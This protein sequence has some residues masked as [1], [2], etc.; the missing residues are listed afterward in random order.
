MISVVIPVYNAKK[1]LRQTVNSV[2][3][4]DLK[5]FEIILVDD[6]STDGTETICDE[7]AE[8]T[9]LIRVIHKINRGVSSA[10]N[11]G[12]DASEGEYITF[13]DADDSIEQHMLSDIISEFVEKDAD[14][15]FCGFNEVQENGKQTN[16]IANLPPRRL[17]ERDIVVNSLLYTGCS[18]N[19][20][21]NSVWGRGYKKE[22]IKKHGLRFED[23]PMGE[24]WMFNM[25]YCD[26][27]QS[28]VYIDKAYYR[29]LR[30]SDSATSRYQPRQF[31]LWLENRQY[32]KSLISK[33]N[34]NID[35]T[36]IN[37]TWI[38]NVL[39]YSLQVIKKDPNYKTK[40]LQ[41]YEH[42]EFKEALMNITLIT[43]KYFQPVF[44]LIR[45]G[46][47]NS[48]VRVLK[49]YSYRLNS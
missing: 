13:V 32:R 38:S 37:A 26:I 27:I 11:A 18:S 8:E 4:Q 36:K 48:A 1:T 5:E 23:R 21:M 42:Q 31:E 12:I 9:D 33:Y 7:L 46:F 22:I 25:K 41:M 6:G 24:D 10:R 43:P 19:S 40:L 16:I 15:V 47:F 17:L 30:N 34:F 39:F 35:Q 45:K 20:Y 49:L 2:L 28:A 3:I 14:M 29:Y 44:W